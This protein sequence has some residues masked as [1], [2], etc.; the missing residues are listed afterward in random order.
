MLFLVAGWSEGLLLAPSRV[1]HLVSE[2]SASPLPYK[3][4]RVM[5]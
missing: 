4:E 1:R 2:P 5:A 3:F